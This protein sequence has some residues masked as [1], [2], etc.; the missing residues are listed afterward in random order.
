MWLSMSWILWFIYFLWPEHLFYTVFPSIRKFWVV[1]FHRTAFDYSCF[2]QYCLRD[3]LIDVTWEDVFKLDASPPAASEV[4]GSGWIDVYIPHWKYQ[5]K[6]YSS[7]WFSAAYI[8]AKAYRNHFF[9]LYKQKNSSAPKMVLDKLA[10]V[11]KGFLMLPNLLTLM[12]QKRYAIFPETWF[13]RLLVN[14]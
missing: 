14:Y 4:C 12:K 8:A 7:P 10:I 13:P 1:P 11:A 6:P 3:H 5:L 9:R 2:N